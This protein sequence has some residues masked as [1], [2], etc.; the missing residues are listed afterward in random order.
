MPLEG[1][2]LIIRDAHI[3]V[4]G[5]VTEHRFPVATVKTL[6]LVAGQ[7][8]NPLQ[9]PTDDGKVTSQRRLT[10]WKNQARSQTY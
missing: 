10:S 2:I 1:T 6:T 7:H 8:A 5:T 9:F 4:A 3:S